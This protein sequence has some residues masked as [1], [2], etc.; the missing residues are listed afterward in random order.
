MHLRCSAHIINLIVNDGMAN[1]DES[2]NVICNVVVYVRASGNKLI[3]F[4]QKL[5]DGILGKAC[6]WM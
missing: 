1:N 3:S 2:V 6:C 4:E 5:G